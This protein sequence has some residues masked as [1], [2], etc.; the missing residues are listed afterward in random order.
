MK[1][2]VKIF[3][4]IF[5]VFGFSLMVTSASLLNTPNFDAAER[6]L[7]YD[8]SAYCDYF[9]RDCKFPDGKIADAYI[10]KNVYDQIKWQNAQVRAYSEKWKKIAEKDIAFYEKMEKDTSKFKWEPVGPLTPFYKRWGELEKEFGTDEANKICVASSP[11]TYYK[12]EDLGQLSEYMNTLDCAAQACYEDERGVYLLTIVKTKYIPQNYI[13]SSEMKKKHKDE[14]VYEIGFIPKEMYKDEPIKLEPAKTQ[15]FDPSV[16]P[17]SDRNLV[18]VS[19][20]EK[21]LYYYDKNLA[22]QLQWLAVKIACKGVYDMAYTGDF[23]ASNPVD[24]YKTSFIKNYLATNDGRASKG[25]TLFEGICFDYADFAYQELSSRKSEYPGIVGFWM[26]GTTSDSSDIIV[27]KIADSGEKSNMTIN[28]T[29]VVV[30]THN[31]IASHGNV[32]NHA[33]VW[34]QSTDGTMYWVDPTWTDNT[35]KPV[36]GIV[37]GGQ[38]I[39]LESDSRLFAY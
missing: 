38:E 18:P 21:S 26:V 2:V 12:R 13:V 23:R 22:Y 33:W 16:I 25:T 15:P 1:K 37:R 27:Y 36:Y 4:C 28:Q 11:V 5:S 6:V 31:R 35:G 30:F 29:P 32:K 34:V 17:D 24:Y 7:A 10:F 19:T 14:F 3:T 20:T 39:Q 9:I 8:V